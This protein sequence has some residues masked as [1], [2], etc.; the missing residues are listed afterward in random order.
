MPKCL[1][2]F[3]RPKAGQGGP[4]SA[5]C[6]TRARRKSRPSLELRQTKVMVAYSATSVFYAYFDASA[7]VKVAANDDAEQPGREAL[8][9]FFHTSPSRRTTSFCIAEALGVFKRKFLKGTLGLDDYVDTTEALLRAVRGRTSVEDVNVLDPSVRK[10]VRRLVRT[11][12]LDVIDCFQ[13]VTLMHGNTSRLVGG[14]QSL[15]VT[16]DDGLARAARAEGARVWQCRSEPS[17]LT[18][19]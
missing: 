6:Q 8:R 1:R 19:G 9:E 17:P 13:I 14:S 15:L 4:S 2:T 11:H 10:E 5:F 12:R 3:L 18:P 7:L 16:A